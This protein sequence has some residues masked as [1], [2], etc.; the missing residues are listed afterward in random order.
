M[1][2]G[3]PAGKVGPVEGPALAPPD[4]TGEAIG[5]PPAGLT[6]TFG[7]GPALFRD[8]N[9][10]DRFGLADRQPKALRTLPHF[11][12]DA[13]TRRA[14]AATSASRPAPTTRR[15]RCTRS[16]TWPGSASARSPS[17]GRSSASGARRPP[18]P[19]SPRRATCSGSRTAPPTSRPRRPT[20][21]TST[22]G[23]APGDDPKAAWLAGGSYLV[24]RRFN[25]TIEVWDRQPLGDQEEFVGRTK[26]TGA[27]L[28]GGEEFTEPDF[29]MPGSDDLPVVAADAHVRLVH[30]DSTTAPGCCAAATTS[31]TAA[32]AR[33][34]RRRPVLPRLLPQ[35]RHPLHPDPERDGRERRADG[36]PQGQ[37]V[38][39]VRRTSRHRPG[40]VRRSG[41]VRLAQSPGCGRRRCR[42]G[43]AR[44]G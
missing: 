36:V 37:R 34:S 43:T 11:P 5:L 29:D 19:T 42:R 8:A 3:K 39:A 1:T 30:P 20:T 16:A 18:R 23:W 41:A 31:S 32:T 13:S 27:P 40:R 6:I 9:G 12:A 33:R 44:R 24:A 17:A 15:S 26:A 21:S 7:F 28:S 38:G 25:M 22:S 4:D 35:P 10:K 14:P 2:A